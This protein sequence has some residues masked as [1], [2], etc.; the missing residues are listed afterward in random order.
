MGKG[1]YIIPIFVPHHGCPHDC[2]FCNQKRITGHT[3]EIT[4]EMVEDQIRQFLKTIEPNPEK[5]VEVA[6]YGGSFTGIDAHHQ[7]QLLAAAFQWKQKGMIQEIRLSTR[8][9]YIDESVLRRLTSFGVNIVELGVQSMVPDVL[10]AS[11]RGHTPKDVINAVK[12]IKAWGI[13][14]G[15]Q[16]MIGLPADSFDQCMY[17]ADQ[18]IELSP[19]FVRIYPTLVIK[20]T[21]LEVLYRKGFYEPLTLEQAL[22]YAETLVLKFLKFD[23]PIIRLGLQPTEDVTLG[24]AVIAGPIHPAFR[25]LVESRIY[26]HMLEIIFQTRGQI[27]HRALLEIQ[28]NDRDISPLV[29]HKRSN[30]VELQKTFEIKGI[31]ITRNNELS[32]GTIRIIVNEKERILYSMKDYAFNTV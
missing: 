25:Q 18:I 28:G 10:K 4:G 20:D 23:I 29:G 22:Q 32:K 6:F 15:L 31:K 8:P 1:H 24:K 5:S 2:V 26:R 12:M 16:M 27:I 9:D 14:I 11:C 13:R 7:E 21:D 17:T 19:D 30:L 3:E